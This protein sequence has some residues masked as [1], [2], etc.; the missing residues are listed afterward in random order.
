MRPAAKSSAAKKS[1]P[2]RT[3][4]SQAT[5]SAND[6][7]LLAV[8]SY[9]QREPGERG[10]RETDANGRNGPCEH[11][12][13]R[14][15]KGVRMANPEARP[16]RSDYRRRSKEPLRKI[17]EERET[18]LWRDKVAELL[19]VGDLLSRQ[20]LAGRFSIWRCAR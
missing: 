9:P 10:E 14:S 7:S 5:H 1:K 11:A 8:Y 17:V 19:V 2:P 20:Q 3:S 4:V 12:L 18:L 15:G 13:S 6:T 16:E